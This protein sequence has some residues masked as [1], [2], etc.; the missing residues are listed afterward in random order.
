MR[1]LNIKRGNGVCAFCRNWND[2]ANSAIRPKQPTG[3]IWEY[4]ETTENICKINGFKKK[5][6]MTC[7]N[8]VC[9]VQQGGYVKRGAR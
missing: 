3:G 6:F 8:Y 2:P 4:D 5:A 9:K 7:A 1:P